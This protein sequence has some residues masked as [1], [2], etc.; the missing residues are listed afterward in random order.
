MVKQWKNFKK[1]VLPT[2]HIYAFHTTLITN[3]DYFP[4][5][6]NQMIF[7]MGKVCVHCKI[8]NKSLCRMFQEVSSINQDDSLLIE[9]YLLESFD[10]QRIV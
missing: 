3:S 4:K 6:I 5:N 7:R 8:C 9:R 2:P 10:Q 1:C